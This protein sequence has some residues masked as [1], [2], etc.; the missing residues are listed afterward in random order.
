MQGL[1]FFRFG[2]QFLFLLHV[3]FHELQSKQ[4]LLPPCGGWAFPC[5]GFSCCPAQGARASEVVARGLSSCGSLDL[6]HRLNSC[7]AW[8]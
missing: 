6:E 8:A 7:G 5:G 1:S 3:G 4:G 2:W